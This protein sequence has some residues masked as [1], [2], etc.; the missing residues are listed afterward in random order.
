MSQ[1][2]QIDK[3]SKRQGKNPWQWMI[4]LWSIVRNP[5]NAIKLYLAEDSKLVNNDEEGESI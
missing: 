3:R 2:Q 4:T 5:S 1:A